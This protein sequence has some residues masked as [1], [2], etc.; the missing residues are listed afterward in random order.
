MRPRSGAV[1]KE[2]LNGLWSQRLALARDE[3]RRPRARFLSPD[4]R[5]PPIAK[6]PLRPSDPVEFASGPLCRNRAL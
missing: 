2:S 1:V 3:L 6:G 4:Q 5:A